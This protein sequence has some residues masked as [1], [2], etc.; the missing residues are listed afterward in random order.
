MMTM[1]LQHEATDRM[2]EFTRLF[3][4]TLVNVFMRLPFAPMNAEH[5]RTR[6][7]GRRTGSGTLFV[8]QGFVEDQYGEFL[9][10]QR[11][12]GVFA[13]RYAKHLISSTPQHRSADL[14][15]WS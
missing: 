3:Q 15:K 12:H 5:K 7:L 6:P 13:L 8:R 9:L 4:R 2:H 10:L 1:R 14:R 11:Q